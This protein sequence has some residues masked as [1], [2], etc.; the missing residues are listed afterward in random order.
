MEDIYVGLLVHDLNTT[1]VRDEK[2][3]FLVYNEKGITR[4]YEQGNDCKLQE[5]FIEHHLSGINMVSLT[6]RVTKALIQCK[7][8][9]E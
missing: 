7:L 5:H 3:H 6:N 8:Q 9:N 2:L 4:Y 1:D